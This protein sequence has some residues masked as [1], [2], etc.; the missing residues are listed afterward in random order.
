MEPQAGFIAWARRRWEPYRTPYH[1]LTEWWK[2]AKVQ[3]V[4]EKRP[5]NDDHPFTALPNYGTISRSVSTDR[6]S[7]PVT[8]VSETIREAPACRIPNCIR[9]KLATTYR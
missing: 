5:H 6:V 2:E 1:P 9:K 3:D 8:S 4:T 7:R